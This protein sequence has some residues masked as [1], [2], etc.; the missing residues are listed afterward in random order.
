[1]RL[2]LG[3]KS[4]RD[5]E[6][7]AQHFHELFLSSKES[8]LSGLGPEELTEILNAGSLR[9]ESEESLYEFISRRFSADETYFC[10]F[11]FIR[12][13]YLPVSVMQDFIAV[14]EAHY[15]RMTSSI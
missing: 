8:I 3:L 13:E 9:L 5:V 2:S 12:F 6:F 11:E 1:L 15:D 10:L 4:S 14:N 7:I